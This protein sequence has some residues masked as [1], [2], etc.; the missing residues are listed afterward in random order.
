MTT[1][2]ISPTRLDEMLGQT[3]P[4][5]SGRVIRLGDRAD[6]LLPLRGIRLVDLSVTALFSYGPDAMVTVRDADG[7]SACISSRN[8]AVVR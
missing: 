2:T 1:T 6:L 4:D 3:V 7:R 8:V 5:R